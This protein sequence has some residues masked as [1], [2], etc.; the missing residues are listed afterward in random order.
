MAAAAALDDRAWLDVTVKQVKST[1]ERLSAA[2]RKMGWLVNPA[3]GNFVL[4][5][6]VSAKRSVSAETSA[7]CYE[8][9]RARKILVRRFP[10]H[11][12]TEKALRIS[13]GT[14]QEIDDFLA[15][16]GV[17]MEG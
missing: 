3:A 6:P 16:I 1:R 13:V 7:H 4:A 14:E 10:Q 15:A 2:L 5:C 9:L 11:R 17:W 8:F 12:L